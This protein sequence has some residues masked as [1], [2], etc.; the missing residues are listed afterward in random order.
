MGKMRSNLTALSDTEYRDR[1]IGSFLVELNA[2]IEQGHEDLA[3]YYAR[4]I[5]S[6]AFQFTPGLR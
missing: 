5:A 6:V 4:E 1:F 3:A 2:R